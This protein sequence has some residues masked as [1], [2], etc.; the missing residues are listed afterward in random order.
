MAAERLPPWLVEAARALTAVYGPRRH[1]EIVIRDP[2]DHAAT[3]R[4]LLTS[5]RVPEPPPPEPPAP[6]EPPP[7]AGARHPEHPFSPEE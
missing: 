2:Y 7:A 4:F 1:I 5:K 3:M 6:P